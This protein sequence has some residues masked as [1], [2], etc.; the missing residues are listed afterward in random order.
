MNFNHRFA[1]N[2]YPLFLLSLFALSTTAQDSVAVKQKWTFLL[3]PYM[4]F[5]GMNGTTGVGTL[6]DVNVDADAGDI[7]NKLKMGA[8]LYFEAAKH[9]WAFSSDII[10]MKLG[11]DATP[12]KLVNSGEVTVKQFAWEVA[13]MRKLLPWLEGG[14]GLRL[15]SL[16]SELDLVTNNIGGG[17]TAKNKSLTQTWVDPILIARI[18]SGMDKKFI[19]KFRADIGGF[20]VGSDIAWQLQA[21]AGYRFSKLFQVT[22]GYRII[23]IDYNKGSNEDRFLYDVDTFGPVIRFGFNF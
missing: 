14:V 11:Q 8:M 18:K 5:P 16:N 1:K 13:G 9:K 21:Y 19:Y 4:M 20:G 3:E 22:G 6:P 2:F 17:T 10:Y 15:N 23:S 12:N 7:F